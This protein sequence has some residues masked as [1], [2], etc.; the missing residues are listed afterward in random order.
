MSEDAGR[1]FLRLAAEAADEERFRVFLARNQSLVRLA[2]QTANARD[3]NGRTLLTEEDIRTLMSVAFTGGLSAGLA[4]ASEAIDT[5]LPS[6]EPP[7][8]S[9]H[10]RKDPSIDRMIGGAKR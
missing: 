9:A 2:V 7:E 5:V 6:E 10:A 1:A 3:A 4:R 8:A